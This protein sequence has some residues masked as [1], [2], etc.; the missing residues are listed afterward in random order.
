MFETSGVSGGGHGEGLRREATENRKCK[1]VRE[2]V[3]SMGGVAEGGR[4]KLEGIRRV[5][6]GKPGEWIREWVDRAEWSG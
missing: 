2:E 5:L 6:F 3:K 4:S 1:G